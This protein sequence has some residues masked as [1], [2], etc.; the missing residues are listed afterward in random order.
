MASSSKILAI[1]GAVAVASAAIWY[2]LNG[3]AV[4]SESYTSPSDAASNSHSRDIAKSDATKNGRKSDSPD[5]NDHG[6][7]ESRPAVD[8]HAPGAGPIVP[9]DITNLADASLGKSLWFKFTNNVGEWHDLW[10]ALHEQDKNRQDPL[11]GPP[12]PLEFE[13]THDA[14]LA[15]GLGPKERMDYGFTL[16]PVAARFSETRYR[17]SI[18]TVPAPP[19]E[20][21]TNP[22][23]VWLVPIGSIRKDGLVIEDEHGNEL[24][25]FEKPPA[26]VVDPEE[27]DEDR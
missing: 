8:P 9:F 17:L 12:E 24:R 3:G 19:V 14:I 11:D 25:V 2:L 10:R 7:K 1:G 5:D 21:A 4:P 23:R 6:S 26:P 16:E 15:I 18:F 13:P 27:P 20:V 22:A